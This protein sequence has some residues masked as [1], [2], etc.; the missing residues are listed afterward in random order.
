MTVDGLLFRP[1]ARQIAKAFALPIF[2]VETGLLDD[3]ANA[4]AIG[5]PH[6]TI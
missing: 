1:L 2:Q 4:K 6:S 5:V 3:P